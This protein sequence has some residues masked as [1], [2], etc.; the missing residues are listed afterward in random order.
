MS[1]FN[2]QISGLN[3]VIERFKQLPKEVEDKLQ[4]RLNE[5]AI[6]TANDAKQFCPV[7]EGFLRNSIHPD[8]KKLQVSVVVAANYSSFI[9]FG[10]RRFAAQ[11]VA[12]L[13]ADWQAFAAQFRGK[14]GGSFEELVMRIKRWVQKKGISEKGKSD[15]AAYAIALS[16]IRNGIHAQPFLYPA[17]QAN[18]IKLEENLKA[19]FKQ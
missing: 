6:N 5:F 14:G 12:S 4:L 18:I 15:S 17:W 11:Y 13:P 3:K 2:V 16:I 1:S 19:D 9:E 7:D 8:L 10:T